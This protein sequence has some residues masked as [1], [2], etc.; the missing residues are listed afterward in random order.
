NRASVLG[1][2]GGV[3]LPIEGHTWVGKDNW[4]YANYKSTDEATAAYVALIEKLNPLI[5]QGLSAAVYTQLTDVERE[6]NGGM[7][8]D[9]AI[10]TINPKRGRAAAS[11]L[12]HPQGWMRMVVPAATTKAQVWRYTVEQP[13]AGWEKPTFEDAAWKQGQSGFGAANTPG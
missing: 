5:V 6:V 3:G 2:F 7:T 4:A 12:Y 8:E 1:E 9:R 11:T 13:A 10:A